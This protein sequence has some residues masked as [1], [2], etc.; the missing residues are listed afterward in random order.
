M[1]LK[2]L[3][4]LLIFEYSLKDYR[5][6]AE[7][8]KR[9]LD[10]FMRKGRP[11]KVRFAPHTA[12]IKVKNLNQWITNELLELA[13]QV[14]GEV[15][16][17]FYELGNILQYFTSSHIPKFFIFRLR[18]RLSLGMSAENLLVKE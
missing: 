3:L 4:F 2:P 18:E 1:P 17:N 6:N 10:G 11:L 13:F 14:F 5:A 9:E 16:Q 7:K 12:A 8:A 15:I